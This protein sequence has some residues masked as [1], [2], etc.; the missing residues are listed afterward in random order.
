MRDYGSAAETMLANLTGVITRHLV[1]V[2]PR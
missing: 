2:R 1:W